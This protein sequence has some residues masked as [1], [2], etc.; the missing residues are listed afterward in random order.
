MMDLVIKAL[1]FWG[2]RLISFTTDTLGLF[3]FKN[4]LSNLITYQLNMSTPH[5]QK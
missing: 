2:N 1:D 3:K 5:M 4:F